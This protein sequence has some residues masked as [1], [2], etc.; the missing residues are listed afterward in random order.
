MGFFFQIKVMVKSQDDYNNSLL[1]SAVASTNAAVLIKAMSYAG[2]H[3]SSQEV[4]YA[5][6]ENIRRSLRRSVG[7]WALIPIIPIGLDN[8]RGPT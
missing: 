5:I 3:I 2:H 7:R 1:A 6:T 4:K 8:R